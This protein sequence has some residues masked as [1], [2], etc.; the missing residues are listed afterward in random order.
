MAP[1]DEAGPPGDAAAKATP[2]WRRTPTIDMRFQSHQRRVADQS[3][4]SH[5]DAVGA[6]LWALYVVAFGFYL[7][8]RGTTVGRGAPAP[9]LAYQ[10]VVLV[11]E[12][13]V[14]TSGAILGLSQA[15]AR[16]PPGAG[17]AAPVFAGRRCRPRAPGAPRA[18]PVAAACDAARPANAV[19]TVCRFSRNSCESA[20]RPARV[21]S[22]EPRKT[23]PEHAALGARRRASCTRTTG[24]GRSAGGGRANRTRRA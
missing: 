11:A 24:R 10:V 21:L 14:F 4:P 12:G 16:G 7:F 8:C 9:L 17:R 2:A 1:L 19:L 13:L 15:R 18:L 23:Q 6:G 5:L 22:E 20:G 3:R